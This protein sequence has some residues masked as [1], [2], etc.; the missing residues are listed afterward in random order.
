MEPDDPLSMPDGK[1][2]DP[3]RFLIPPEALAAFL[4]TFALRSFRDIADGDYIAARMAYRADLI[5]QA[6]WAVEQALEK[7]L[8]SIL[9]LQRIKWKN[10]GHSVLDT[11]DRL[12]AK[13]CCGFI[14]AATEIST[15]QKE[16]RA[17]SILIAQYRGLWTFWTQTS[18]NSSRSNF[19]TMRGA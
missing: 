4:N 1:H 9:L 15:N 3:Q 16:S 6:L 12:E 10:K 13:F 17:R 2:D 14:H 7:Y 11:L 5:P 19:R 18:A 8:K